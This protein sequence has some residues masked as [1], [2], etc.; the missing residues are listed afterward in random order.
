MAMHTKQNLKKLLILA[1]ALIAIW[2]LSGCNGTGAKATETPAPTETALPPTP[3]PIPAALKVNGDIVLQSLYDAWRASYDIAQESGSILA[4]DEEAQQTV[5]NELINQTLLAQGAA[6]NGYTVSEED[7][8]ARLASLAESA[9]GEAKLTAWQQANGFDEENFRAAL[10]LAMAAAWQR[11]QVAASVPQ[12]AEHVK[13]RQ[14][15]LLDEDTANLYLSQLESGAEFA[16]IANIVDPALGGDL[17]WF[18][19]GYLTQVSVEE[20][21]FALEPGQISEI[22]ESD[23][24]YHIV[25]VL[26][27][28]MRPLN[29]EA[30]SFLQH[31][32]VEDWL[33]ERREQSE[34]EILLP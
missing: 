33:T 31:Q 21:A 34:I 30:R 22:I 4:S 19:R 26:D 27:K 32:A 16:T 20:A 9:G 10:R 25:Q 7:L 6:D 17:N 2:G 8:D 18:P 5:L 29:P 15:L 13:A 23:L 1:V 14:L 12:E 11:D 3:T 28:G 24:G